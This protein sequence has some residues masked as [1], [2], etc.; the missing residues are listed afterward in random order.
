MA[1]EPTR[2]ALDQAADIAA[3][4]AHGADGADP[5]ALRFRSWPRLGLAA[6]EVVQARPESGELTVAAFGLI[7]PGGVLPRHVTATV[8][9][10]LRKRSHALHA[11]LDLNARRLL[12]LYVKAG[13]KYRPTRNPEPAEKVLAAAIGMGTP[14]LAGRIAPPLPT[15]LF[16]AGNLA[17]RTRSAERLRAMLEEETG[18]R[19]EIEEFAGGW[20]RLPETEQTRLGGGRTGRHAALGR[21]AAAGSQVWDP[22]ARFIIR[23]GPL[24]RA[25]FEA[26]LP[27]TP[28]HRVLVDLARLFVG[29]DTGFALNLVLAKEEIPPLA[30]GG[31]EARLGQSSWLCGAA[32]RARDG[33]E[34]MFEAR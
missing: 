9:A 22:Q 13:A 14:G 28:R 32:P 33:T 7:G 30:L 26:L 5:L 10:E 31:A 20:V 19:V 2:F 29:L 3:R 23:I 12:G 27:G 6:G 18:G 15:L 21:G 17:A 16:H 11:F 34:P 25:E 8:A 1:R 4:V 24:R